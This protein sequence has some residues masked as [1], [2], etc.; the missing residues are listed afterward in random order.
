MVPVVIHSTQSC[1]CHLMQMR[2]VLSPTPTT[3]KYTTPSS[4]LMRVGH[5]WPSA[6]VCVLSAEAICML[7]GFM[8]CSDKNYGIR[9]RA[10]DLFSAV[11]HYHRRLH[12]PA[13]KTAICIYSVT[14]TH[15]MILCFVGVCRVYCP[16]F[17]C[18]PFP[19]PVST[20]S[21]QKLIVF[22]VKQTLT[23]S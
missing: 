6:R 7:L 14:H 17:P 23:G 11:T 13:D 3:M 5:S 12:N 16:I 2:R 20:D 8:K 10:I 21:G 18:S 9:G 4:S 15:F 1:P 22:A 19:G